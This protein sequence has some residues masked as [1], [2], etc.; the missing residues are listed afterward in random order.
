MCKCPPKPKLKLS[1]FFS[2]PPV[3]E[4]TGKDNLK[5]GSVKILIPWLGNAWGVTIPERI[6]NSGGEAIACCNLIRELWD[7]R[8]RL[9]EILPVFRYALADVKWWELLTDLRLEAYKM[10][11][12][13]SFPNDVLISHGLRR[14]LA[15]RKL[16]QLINPGLT[17]RN[18]EALVYCA[19]VGPNVYLKPS[20][21]H[22]S[23]SE[24]SDY[25][26]TTLESHR[27]IDPADAHSENSD[28]NGSPQTAAAL[29][30]LAWVSAE[31]YR[32]FFGGL[33]KLHKQKFTQS[34]VERF[35]E[36][37]LEAMEPGEHF[38]KLVDL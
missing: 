28:G 24:W 23:S 30:D 12:C 19:V 31:R 15:V 9:P 2:N 36:L 3:D 7:A 18:L 14:Y 17:V 5:Q 34:K 35:L 8:G 20:E 1:R 25:W 16:S 11:D 38:N 32:W 13:D 29:R 26:M 4:E 10:V 33:S 21:H 27:S 22:Q 6:L 37:L